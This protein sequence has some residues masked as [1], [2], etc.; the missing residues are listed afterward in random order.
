[1]SLQKVFYLV[2][3]ISLLGILL[4]VFFVFYSWNSDEKKEAITAVPNDAEFILKISGKKIFKTEI[5]EILKKQDNEMMALIQRSLK[6]SNVKTEEIGIDFLS[7]FYFFSCGDSLQGVSVCLSDTNQ[8]KTQISSH[9]DT[10]AV[11]ALK[12]NVGLILWSNGFLSKKEMQKTGKKIV[13]LDQ[14]FDENRF[15]QK[16][17]VLLQA[18][19][20]SRK[21]ENLLSSSF[22]LLFKEEQLKLYGDFPCKPAHNA[23]LRPQ[24]FHFQINSL[25]TALQQKIAT[26]LTKTSL[27]IPLID[28]ISLNYEG[29]EIKLHEKQF[30]T[31]PKVDALVKFED[32]IQ[33]ET[34]L[35]PLKKQKNKIKIENENIQILE[36]NY[37]IKQ[38]DEK[39]I[40]IGINPLTAQK[41]NASNHLFLQGNP[42]I[43]TKIEAPALVL[44]LLSGT[45]EYT[46][47]NRISDKVEYLSLKIESGTKRNLK[48][49]IH[50][51]KGENACLELTKLL[52]SF[53]DLN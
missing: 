34:L 13:A 44:G 51:K 30:W 2:R 36:Q 10:N 5:S 3:F 50:F 48:G 32:T 39:T 31:L 20:Q 27:D 35:S 46:I 43:L 33:V 45:K 25:P 21:R 38:I 12:N 15:T 16:E 1:M 47:A 52:L 41:H 22:T 26:F 14:H 9:L 49:E 19:S 23:S 42:T 28:A 8:F 24:N 18:I 4:V 7:D 11:F 53:Y 6:K 29:M 37:H 17:E 40:Y